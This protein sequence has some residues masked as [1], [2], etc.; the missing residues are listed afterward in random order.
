LFEKL[1]V[2]WNPTGRPPLRD[3]YRD[4]IKLRKQHRAFHTDDVIWL[5]N[6]VPERVVTIMR[7]DGNDAFVLLVNLS[8]SKASGSVELD[9][10][11]EFQP[12]NIDGVPKLANNPFPDFRLG[13]YEW[14]IYHRTVSK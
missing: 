13:G 12:V 6:S 3:I 9:A 7:Q 10:A 4:L 8:S 5:N 14:R 11:E 1:P 2:F